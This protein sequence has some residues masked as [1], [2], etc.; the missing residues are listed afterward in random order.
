MC[1]IY[2]NYKWLRVLCIIL[3]SELAFGYMYTRGTC[4]YESYTWYTTSTTFLYQID[5]CMCR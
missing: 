5:K 4:V 2:V 3:H 1:F